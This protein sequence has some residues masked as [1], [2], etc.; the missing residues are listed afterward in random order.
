[1]TLRPDWFLTMTP[2]RI[3]ALE[4]PYEELSHEERRLRRKLRNNA[5]SARRQ[6]MRAIDAAKAAA[7]A[8]YEEREAIREMTGSYRAACA[9]VAGVAERYSRAK[10]TTGYVNVYGDYIDSYFTIIHK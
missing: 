10:D 6:D 3:R 5:Y 8:K 1:M 2:E 9:D 7:I 4:T